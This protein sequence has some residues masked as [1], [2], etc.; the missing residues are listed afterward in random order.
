MAIL[1][2]VSI[3]IFATML[4]RNAIMKENICVTS[5]VQVE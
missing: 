3:T 2:L 1:L 4:R 5:I